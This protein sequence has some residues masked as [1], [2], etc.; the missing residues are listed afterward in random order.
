MGYL[1]NNKQ[2]LTFCF[3]CISLHAVKFSEKISLVAMENFS[4]ATKVV[5]L[6]KI[7]LSYHNPDNDNVIGEHTYAY[8]IDTVSLPLKNS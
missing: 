6:F 2:K 4:M 8:S 3:I 1:Y 7:F 5:C